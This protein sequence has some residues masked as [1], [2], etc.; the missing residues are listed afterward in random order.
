M[1]M[2]VTI[3]VEGDCEDGAAGGATGAQLDELRQSITA[4]TDQHKLI[5]NR[6]KL[7]ADGLTANHEALMGRLTRMENILM[8]TQAQVDDLTARVG[9]LAPVVTSISDGVA[10]IRQDIA[11]IRA[12]NPGVDLSAL[13]A[14]VTGI[15]GDLSS[16]ATTVADLDAENPA[17]TPTDPTEPTDPAPV[18][19][20]A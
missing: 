12:E 14:T 17:A 9:A 20:N 3:N 4:L 16:A 7:Q 2:Q 6:L 13:E 10:N 19:P 5:V 11:N 8:A 1:G 15:E 18:D